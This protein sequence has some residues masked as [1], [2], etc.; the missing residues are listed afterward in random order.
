MKNQTQPRATFF[1]PIV[2]E[3]FIYLFVLILNVP[4]CRA[5][6]VPPPAGLV[7]W[8]QAEGDATDPV[9]LNNGTI[10][11]GTTFMTGEVGQAFNFDG[12]S[13]AVVIPA[14][15]SLAFQSLTIEGWLLPLDLVTPRPIVEYSD[16][17]SASSMNFWYNM[18]PNISPN[19][20]GLYGFI[21]DP[22]GSAYVD[23]GSAPGLLSTNQWNHLALTWDFDQHIITLYYNG[24][25]VGAATSSVPVNTHSFVN[26]NL[27]YRPVGSSDLWGGRRHLGGLDEVS[28]YNRA[29]SASEVRSIYTAGGAGKCGTPTSPF[30]YL[31]PTD[32]AVFVG[33]TASFT[34]GAGGAP[35]LS[36]QWML[37]GMNVSKATN[38]LLTLTNVQFSQAGNYMVQIT[39][40]IGMT[41]SAAALLT[42]NPLPPCAQVP[43]DAV[44][45]WRGDGNPLDE[46]GTNHGIL[47]GNTILGPGTVRQGF[48]FDGN[49]DA[50]RVG[51]PAELQLQDL[52]IEAWVKRS[53]A[54]AAS[55]SSFLGFVFAYGN[56]GYGLGIQNNGVLM[57]TRVG[58]DN[59]TSDPILTDTSFHHIAVTKEGSTV[60]FYVDG[61]AYP[62]GA[63]DPGF[64]FTKAAAIGANGDD[65]TS[66]FLGTIDEL[67]IYNRALAESE[68]QAIYNALL[69][70]KCVTPAAPSIVFQPQSQTVLAGSNITFAVAAR[71]SP[72]VTYQWR[73][74]GTNLAG[75][76]GYSLNLT[77]IQLTNTGNYS[78]AI[79]NS[80]GWTISSNATLSVKAV[81]AYGNNQQFTNSQYTF[82]GQVTIRLQ[83][84]YPNGLTFYTLDGC[85]PTFSSH[86]YSTPFVLNHDAILRAVGYSPDFLQFGESDPVS[87]LVIPY[88]TLTATT[89]GGGSIALN[90]SVG[91]YLSNT[92]VTLTA[93]P[94]SGWT[95][96][97]WLGDAPGTNASTNLTMARN[98]S[99]RAVFGTRLSTTAAGGG[100]V[101]LNPSGGLY[102][103]GTAVQLTAIPQPGNYF[104]IWGNAA[105][106]NTNPL[107]FVVRTANPT[108]SSVFGA[109]S[110]G[111][112]A[113]TVI[114]VGNGRVAASPRQNLFS[115]GAAV[116]ITATPDSG[117]SFAG[118][119]GDTNGTRNPLSLTM[120]QSKV[121]YA[122][123]TARPSL[124]VRSSF[125]GLKP[126]GF[127]MTLSGLFGAR[128]E[129]DASSD[130][131]NWTPLATLTNTYGAVQ[132]TD[133]AATNLLHRFY[134]AS[135]VP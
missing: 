68:I 20:G 9:G 13:S 123:F 34:V 112:A 38:A 1:L 108:V 8:W 58:V 102:P 115:V 46:I 42:V 79:T 47:I 69:S 117:Q 83:N 27:G 120:D 76:T 127:R 81:F 71:G 100:S 74:N 98:L 135:L 121:I 49:G 17:T 110:S 84:G 63:Y 18:G 75:A 19:H 111:Q 51:N 103:F 124:S 105:T 61:V 126:E 62:V 82:N 125:E 16:P 66:S 119:S 5:D 57:F 10:F 90:P 7:G 64:T 22:S 32:Q 50:V 55:L 26:V 132:F 114:P 48:L 2:V 65:L 67:T 96:F 130:L 31:Q 24:A 133:G 128:Y 107:S 35:P 14:S 56:G 60:V 59:V 95:F 73:F 106:G 101:A 11:N 33:G 109:L 88:Y 77:N 93:T 23:V 12:T 39:N 104:G 21:R 116:S 36:Y 15:S 70:G 54:S 40:S 92:V 72:I 94:S 87:I 131:T 78:V 97:Q 44:S 25:A 4:F 37:N 3:G 113:L 122:N 52:T 41:N 28:I 30:I 91:T 45:W 89:A 80:L 99:M 6:C 134:R 85:T 53:S 129:I 86:Q 118:W 43:T 29:L